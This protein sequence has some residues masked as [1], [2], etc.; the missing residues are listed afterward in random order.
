MRSGIWIRAIAFTISQKRVPETASSPSVT[1]NSATEVAITSE[2]VDGAEDEE[3]EHD[4]EADDRPVAGP[5]HAPGEDA[6]DQ[7][8]ARRSWTASGSRR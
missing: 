3:D 8:G 4:L 2:P 1:A 7:G 5:P 6:H